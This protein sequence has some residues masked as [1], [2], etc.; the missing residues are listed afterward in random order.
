MH[1]ANNLLTR[2]RARAGL[3]SG[4]HALAL[5]ISLAAVCPVQARAAASVESESID[6]MSEPL[7]V[8]NYSPVASLLGFPVQR[9]AQTAPAGEFAFALHG[10]VSNYYINDASANEFLNLDGETG[11]VALELRYSLLD[12]LDVQL[13]VPLLNIS[14]GDLDKLI[15]DWHDVWGMPDGGRP[16]VP[17]NLLDYRYANRAGA[18][19]SLQDSASGLGDI[20]LSLDYAFYRRDHSAVSLLVG[21]K[22]ASGDDDDFLGSGGDDVFAGLRF[23]GAHLSDLPLYWHGQ[24]GYLHAGDSDL[25]EGIQE[26]DLWFAG[27]SLDWMLSQRWSLLAQIDSHAA[28]TSSNFTALG[29]DAAMFSVGARWRFSPG[30]SVDVSVVEDILVET[31]ADITFQASLRYRG[32]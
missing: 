28:P 31:A 14:G 9:S 13:E 2:S 1:V 30:W 3:A 17:R 25:L 29:D 20:S 27:L 5:L 18:G 10:S 21:Y 8:K 11:R 19:F 24:V 4:V 12:A 22:F 23:S 15:D 26:Q 32:R 6:P 7:Y 16:S